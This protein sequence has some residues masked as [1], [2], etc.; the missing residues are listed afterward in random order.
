MAAK[1]EKCVKACSAVR[2]IQLNYRPIKIKK[3]PFAILYDINT[4]LDA[5]PH[6]HGQFL[7]FL[8]LPDIRMHVAYLK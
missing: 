5:F 1:L 2:N 8:S 4:G 3:I 7:R 6:A